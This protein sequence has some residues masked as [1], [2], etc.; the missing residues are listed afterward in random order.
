ME[1][2][3]LTDKVFHLARLLKK[4]DEMVSLRQ[5]YVDLRLQANDRI[6]DGH[7]DEV[8]G[9]DEEIAAQREEYLKRLGEAEAYADELIGNIE[10]YNAM[11]DNRIS[12]FGS[13]SQRD[14]F[15]VEARQIAA[16]RPIAIPVQVESLFDPLEGIRN[17]LAARVAQ[18]A[19]SIFAAH[20]F[21][22]EAF[23]M[24]EQARA[25]R[26]RLQNEFQKLLVNWDA[27][28]EAYAYDLVNGYQ[29][30]F[31]AAV[32]S[33]N[34]EEEQA[35]NQW[36]AEFDALNAEVPANGVV[37]DAA[38]HYRSWPAPYSQTN[39]YLDMSG[40]EG[41]R[42]IE[43]LGLPQDVQV[44]DILHDDALVLWSHGE[45]V[46]IR[47][48]EDEFWWAF[49][50]LKDV[51]Y[52]VFIC[53]SNGNIDQSA[54]LIRFVKHVP[55][56]TGGKVFTDPHEIADILR[57][58]VRIMQDTLQNKLVGY[59]S[60][61][62]FNRKN[63]AK[64]IAWRILY[65][66]HFPVGFDE[67]S[68][69]DLVS[70]IR[71][72]SR[73]GIR[74]IVQ[75]D[76]NAADANRYRTDTL[77]QTV[78]NLPQSFTY[79]MY[80]HCWE[81]DLDNRLAVNLEE[82]P[83]HNI[84]AAI[85]KTAA[86]TRENRNKPIDL[87]SILP[88]AR[89]Q[90]CSSAHRINLPI[91]IRDDGSVCT[92]EFGDVVGRGSSHF[93]LVVGPTGS[94]K[95]VLLHTIIMGALASYPPSELQVYLMDFKEGTEFKS[96][97]DVSLP[98]LRYVA[99]DSMQQFGESVFT[100]LTQEM[101]RRADAFK[102]ASR[103]GQQIVNIAEYRDNGH[104]MPR[105]LVVVDEFQELFDCNRDRKCANRVAAR[106]GELISKG[107]AFG[108]HMVFA[109]QTLH[110]IFEGNYSIT[111]SSLEEMHVRIGLKCSEREYA[112][113]MGQ[114]V[115]QLCVEKTDS[116]KGSGVFSLDYVSEMPF[117]MR[118]AYLDPSRR[119]KVLKQIEATYQGKD[120]PPTKVF[121]G[122]DE[123]T[124]PGSTLA[125]VSVE[126]QRL[127]IGQP[128]ALGK[129]VGMD[130]SPHS[131]SNML[132]VGE[133]RKMLDRIGATVT[134]QMAAATAAGSHVFLFDADAM[135]AGGE[136]PSP[137]ASL[138]A[139]GIP[140]SETTLHCARNAFQ[141]IPLLRDAY[142]LYVERR[143]ELAMGTTDTQSLA[144]VYLAV[145]NYQQVDPIVR[146]MEG[147]SA[148]E[149]EAVVQTT[150]P[151]PADPLQ[152]MLDSL[153][154]EFKE[155]G[156]SSSADIPPQKM[157]RTLLESGHLC[158]FHSV[159]TCGST[160]VL[161]RLL[162][163]DIAPFNYRIVMS[164]VINSHVY[165]DT[166]I[167]MKYVRDNCVLYTDGQGEAFLIRPFALAQ[168]KRGSR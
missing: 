55:E 154:A 20:D 77:V 105:I 146:L 23:T 92:L 109:T 71:Q 125:K 142:E 95:S 3:S 18:K 93:A 120:F 89:F 56:V 104:S 39:L 27:D 60:V 113:L 100:S 148:A 144:P 36:I 140:Y 127:Y 162:R 167:D 57:S 47:K 150:A 135:R 33:I 9:R 138:K 48:E 66:S 53:S 131:T 16:A 75:A 29:A 90:K 79:D 65:I 147:K 37:P 160:A 151:E 114:D 88:R 97:A 161:G 106:F 5:H 8:N 25:Y 111:K 122:A 155:T 137:L 110:R 58:H 121:R 84:A 102:A 76:M 129:N 149:Y 153:S 54:E 168:P 124:M 2:F 12:G 72:G 130:V 40:F 165:V 42:D 22:V 98:H 73:A 63:K 43:D 32:K 13:A 96:Y 68:T 45:S 87:L 69:R 4:L 78:K 94:G 115:A 143:N 152:A 86:R 19:P 70:L 136:E 134:C 133:D 67:A 38:G 17:Q 44:F 107:R 34:W 85:E 116:R 164:S 21:Y 141:V 132:V 126:R 119:S 7:K 15:H 82:Y 101:A 117:G 50:Q 64:P 26:P 118:V 6:F 99:L 41:N 28:A 112:N 62:Q 157:L 52:R 103:N 156:S 51:D 59:S 83:R 123:L 166:D 35:C 14:A 1:A 108:I 163:S 158:G 74:V 30:D 61:D 139:A 31:E 80:T 10:G 11:L 159:F 145:L 49:D 24:V 91:G 128:V 81:S 46:A